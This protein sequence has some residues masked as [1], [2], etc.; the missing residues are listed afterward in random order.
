M[1]FKII[2]ELRDFIFPLSLYCSNKNVELAITI[3]GSVSSEVK[4]NGIIV[5]PCSH[6]WRLEF[7]ANQEKV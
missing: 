7:G 4:E 3:V 6:F 2:F 1:T 5:S